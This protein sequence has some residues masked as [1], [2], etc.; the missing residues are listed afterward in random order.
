MADATPSRSA[1]PPPESG[2]DKAAI[3]LLTLGSDVAKRVLDHLS[4]AEVRTLSQA[5]A[6]VR[7]I[8]RLQAAAVH[9]EAWRWLSARDGY[10]VDGE[11]FVRRIVA[12][13]GAPRGGH[14]PAPSERSA[15]SIGSRL[16]GVAPAAVAKVLGE[17]HPQV[18]ALVLANLGPRQAAEVLVRL[19]EAAQPDVLHR[20]AALRAVPEDVLADV[21]HAIAGQV[22]RLGAAAQPGVA[23]GGPK[24]AAEIMNMVGSHAEERILAGLDQQAPDV[25]EN[26]RNLMLTFEDL[27]RLD[28][29]GMQTLLKDIGRDDLLLAMKT[30]S[31]SMQERILTNMSARAREIMQEDLSTM[32]PVRLKDVER[33]QATIV[34]AAR[35]LAEEH[36][37]QLG[38]SD[39]DA[40]V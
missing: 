5:M 16:D 17:E 26:I 23:T 32:G 19:P 22:E 14:E 6:R 29:R 35:R 27:C 8:P 21:G 7:A 37:I 18:M 15:R 11:D 39:D 1:L 10:L 24:L 36:K 30:A 25:A 34:L 38:V 9:E 20:I 31:P 33:S 40:L 4:E 3:L 28:N 2:L 12:G 13:A